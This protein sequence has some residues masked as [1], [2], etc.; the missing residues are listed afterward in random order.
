LACPEIVTR[1]T[2]YLL[3]CGRLGFSL[4]NKSSSCQVLQVVYKVRLGHPPGKEPEL[5]REVAQIP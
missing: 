1:L 2:G 4:H 3:T 5:D